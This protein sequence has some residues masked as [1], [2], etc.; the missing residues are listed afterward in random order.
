M[1]R[2]SS[3][4]RYA[5]AVFQ[6][7]RERDSLDEWLDDLGALATALQNSDFSGLLDAPQV[8]A[9]NKI[10]AIGQAI[11]DAVDPL[12]LNLLCILASRNLAHLV[13]GVLAKFERML[14]AHRGIERAEVVTAV[15][16]DAGQQEKIAELLRGIVGKKVQLSAVVEPEIIGGLF[17]RVGDQVIDG[18]VRTKL[19]TMR[20]TI[21][22]KA[23]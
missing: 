1:P 13:P 23:S 17:A 7:A 19:E 16:L 5:Q 15:P 4:T 22:D 8:P 14:D 18:S 2:A 10:D 20:R 12:A 3:P 11:G 21:V 6:I 9:S